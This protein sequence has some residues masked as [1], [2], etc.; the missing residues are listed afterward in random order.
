M[1][2]K[3]VEIKEQREALKQYIGETKVYFAT[4]GKSGVATNNPQIQTLM[5]QN[6]RCNN[7]V[8][9]DHLWITQTWPVIRANL[10]CGDQI[11]LTGVAQVYTK[12][13][14]AEDYGLT[15]ISNVR[16][17]RDQS[18]TYYGLAICQN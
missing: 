17:L 15:Q 16:K 8:M 2:K 5:L 13:Q 7:R 18:S 11:R 6:V 1:S 12:K 4:V 9:C 3:K 14:G 10:F